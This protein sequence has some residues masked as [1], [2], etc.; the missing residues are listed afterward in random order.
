[1]TEQEKQQLVDAV[2]TQLKQ[3]GTDVS[4]A[5]V[6][7]DVNGVSY[8]LCYD[9]NGNIVRVSPDTINQQEST[10]KD[11]IEA[12]AVGVTSLETGLGNTNT[13]LAEAKKSI[14]S[15]LHASSS[16]DSVTITGKSDVGRTTFSAK[17]PSA[18]TE[19]AGVMS[20]KDKTKLDNLAVEGVD[21]DLNNYVSD[22]TY[23][24]GSK[25]LTNVPILND[26]IVS[27]RLTVLRAYDGSSLVIT[28]VL[29]LNN[30]GG[31][32]GNIYIRSNQNGTWKPWG[33]LQTNVEVGQITPDDMSNL[34]DNG[35]YSGVCV[36][37]TTVETFVLIVINNYLAATQAGFGSY[38]SQLKYAIDLN[39]GNTVKTRTRDAYGVWNEWSEI[40]GS[41]YELPQATVDTLG[42]VRLGTGPFTNNVIAYSNDLVPV[43]LDSEARMCFCVGL[44]LSGVSSGVLNLKLKGDGGLRTSS[45]GLYVSLGSGFE[46]A[47]GSV[48]LIVRNEFLEERPF[49][50]LSKRVTANNPSGSEIGIGLDES[51]FSEGL[52]GVLTLQAGIAPT[53]VTWDSTSDMD[54][55][56]AAGVYDIT[57]TRESLYD[58]LPIANIGE[59]ATIAA[60]LIV[61]VTPEGATTY[62]HS[63]GQTLILSNAEGKET[64]VYTRN[65]N[66]TIPTGGASYTITWS[67]WKCLQGMVEYGVVT[68]KYSWK[69]TESPTGNAPG[70]GM[71][72]F[73]ENGMYSGVYTDDYTLQSPTFV[74]TFVLVVINDYAV[75]SQAGTPR[76]ISQ[77]KYAT[78]T[79]TGQ[80]TVKKRVGTGD[81]SISW[82]DWEEIGGGSSEVDVTDA[83]KTYGLPT[84]VQQG[85][86]NNNTLY[87]AIIDGSANLPTLDVN[88][89]IKT[90]LLE[91]HNGSALLFKFYLEKI[92]AHNNYFI[93]DIKCYATDS[94]AYYHY[95]HFV[96][97][98]D[99]SKVSVTKNTAILE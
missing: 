79:L 3:D 13:D 45:D 7:E 58:D 89:K 80:C 26:S 20:V 12:L 16:A 32:E 68:D 30:L 77:L 64:K 38:I 8:V 83:I 10:N 65:G 36:D 48:S 1:M 81:D 66:R 93:Y 86:V 42:G 24:F 67:N 76:R 9:T 33:K 14:A 39:R 61:T 69:I 73:T 22:G 44:G 27:A 94:N 6:V 52:D 63:I 23:F 71:H 85:L 40:G 15:S 72:D 88:D 75:S 98:S 82:G 99:L 37:G 25:K 50:Q 60:R 43:S 59:N 2:I 34:T 4:S 54:D 5:T 49:L 90:F 51:I 62:R 18:T 46:I 96:V 56:I 21:T 95:Y 31:G 55:Y 17:V 47:N 91:S 74:E 97:N 35:I 53:K 19:S 84:L 70:F 78:D 57:G 92:K 11:A 41:T 28:Q 87:T 29:N